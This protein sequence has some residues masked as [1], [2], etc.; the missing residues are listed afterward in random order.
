MATA[1]AGRETSV[2]DDGTIASWTAEHDGYARLRPPAVHRRSV[3]LDR[4]ARAVEITDALQ[5][6]TTTCAW[7]STSARTFTQNSTDSW[8]PYA[9]RHLGRPGE[10]P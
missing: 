3:R 10:Q 1:R 6:A 7:P 5:V 4:D 9:G 2:T 8:R